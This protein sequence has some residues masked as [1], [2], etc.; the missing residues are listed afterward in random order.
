MEI[1]KNILV[2]IQYRLTDEENNHLNPDDDELIYLHGGYGQIFEDFEKALEGKK[3]GDN[4]KVTLSPQ[5]AFG[6]YREDLVVQEPIDELPEDIFIG[7]ELDGMDEVS[8]ETLIYTVTD[9][10]DDFAILNANHP[11]AGH[12]VTFEGTIMELQPLSDEEATALLAY[13]EEHHCHHDK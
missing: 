6:L 1:T 8:N 13:E 3:V 2:N 11:F 4:F 7:M 5:R 10:E 9:M 12:T